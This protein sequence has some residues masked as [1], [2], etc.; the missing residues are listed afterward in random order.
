MEPTPAPVGTF[1]ALTGAGVRVKIVDIGANPL[2]GTPPY[3]VMLA[4]QDADI[5]GFEPNPQALAQ[6]ND[7]K[8]PTETYLPYAIGDGRRHTLNF[9]QAPGMTSLLTPD[10]QVL[11]LF[12]GFPDWGKVTGTEEIDTRRLDDIDETAGVELIKID[13]Q[14]GELMALSNAL[15]RLT[16]TLVIQTEVEF[17]PLYVGQPLFSEVEMFLRGRGFMLHRFYPTVSRAIRPMLIENN[18]YAPFSQV[19]WAD[20]IFVRDITRLERLSNEQL[21]KS[22]AILHDCYG[23]LDLVLHLLTEHDRRTGGTLSQTYLSRLQGT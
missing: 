23:S 4:S 3:Q 18:I 12:H 16:T 11:N 17:M 6:L 22:C 15:A 21:L 13:I 20:A 7:A 8:G 1:N 14:G 9:C 19:V 2:D 5:V 10:E